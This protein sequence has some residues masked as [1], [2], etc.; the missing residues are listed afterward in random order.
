[1][2]DITIQVSE[3]AGF[4]LFDQSPEVVPTAWRQPDTPTD[5]ASRV[6]EAF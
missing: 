3:Q 4:G 6:R 5:F 2:N 1:L